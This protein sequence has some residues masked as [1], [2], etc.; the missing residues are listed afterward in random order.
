MIGNPSP[1]QHTI[2]RPAEGVNAYQCS[3]PVQ[4]TP[5]LDD[6]K[7]A[8]KRQSVWSAFWLEERPQAHALPHCTFAERS[9]QQLSVLK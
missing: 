7:A 3:E 5:S 6:C 9:L 2:S 1:H 8:A 4:H